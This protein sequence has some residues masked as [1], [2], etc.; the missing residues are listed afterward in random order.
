[1]IYGDCASN[2]EQRDPP[3]R[4][5]LSKHFYMKSFTFLS[6]VSGGYVACGDSRLENI[7]VG[8]ISTV[9]QYTQ[10]RISIL[11]E[12]QLSYMLTND[13]FI[14]QIPYVFIFIFITEIY[15]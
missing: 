12:I 14:P 10:S 15:F 11:G 5:C 2:W 9:Q 3:L 13:I 4:C 1:M 8:F 7:R 6:R